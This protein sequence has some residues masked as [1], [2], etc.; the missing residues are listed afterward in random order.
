[1]SPSIQTLTTSVSA[2]SW[3]MTTLIASTSLA[4]SFAERS[5]SC[6]EPAPVP[7]PVW[8]TRGSA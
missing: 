1:M 5:G 7:G 6:S 3:P 4:V 2:H 8:R